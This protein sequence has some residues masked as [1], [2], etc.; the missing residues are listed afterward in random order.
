MPFN[1][2]KQPAYLLRLILVSFFVLALMQFASAQTVPDTTIVTTTDSLPVK[3][4]PVIVKV[5]EPAPVTDSIVANDPMPVPAGITTTD[6]VSKKPWFYPGLKLDTA[7]AL[8]IQTLFK[9]PY[10]G[11]ASKPVVVHTNIKKFEGKELIFYSLVALLLAFALLR[12]AFPKYFNDLFRLLF[13]T[14]LK[15]KQVREQLMQTPL[16]SLLLNVFFVITGGL[17]IDIVLQHFDIAPVDNFWLMFVYCAAGL[18]VIYAT[19]FI[20]LKLSGWIFNM[21]EGADT[22]IFIVFIIN[23]VIGVFLLPFLVLLSFMQGGTYY[24]AL[25]LSWC[26][27]GILLVSRFLLTYASVRNQVKFNPFHFFLYLCA[28]EIAP[29]LLIYKALLFFFR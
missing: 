18:S 29:L 16:P 23:K 6:S 11:F 10:Y 28:F 7:V 14:T 17:Y 13:R 8:P 5:K 22:Y 19:K 3:P 24:L 2:A 25:R 12:Q 27:I 21:K 15:Q 20:G 4:K 1:F 9:H 26:G